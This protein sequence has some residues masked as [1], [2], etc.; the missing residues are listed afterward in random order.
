MSAR[1]PHSNTFNA[2]P[3]LSF[4]KSTRAALQTEQSSEH[5]PELGEKAELMTQQAAVLQLVHS[6]RTSP[7]KP[8][9]GAGSD[10]N[11]GGPSPSWTTAD[12]TGGF[13]GSQR[14]A[15]DERLSGTEQD[16][17]EFRSFGE[18]MLLPRTWANKARVRFRTISP[19]S[20]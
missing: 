17:V 2:I 5:L 10:A 9:P 16:S 11:F 3:E 18:V 12:V 19:S 6:R 8:A 1:F 13:S 7:C 15:A 14:G 20:C 4:L